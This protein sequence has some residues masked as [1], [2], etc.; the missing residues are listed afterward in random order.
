MF[1]IKEPICVSSLTCQKGI[2]EEK[3]CQMAISFKGNGLRM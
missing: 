2:L 1:K 3:F